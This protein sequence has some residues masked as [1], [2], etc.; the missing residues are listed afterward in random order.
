MQRYGKEIKIDRFLMQ[1]IAECM[2]SRLR[3]RV[4]SEMAPCTTEEFLERYCE[5]DRY[6]EN[7]L[8]HQFHL[9]F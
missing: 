4:Q 3:D 6:F 5:Y 9:T 1:A 2:N 8:L 7:F